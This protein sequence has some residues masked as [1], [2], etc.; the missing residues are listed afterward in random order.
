MKFSSR[1]VAVLL[2]MIGAAMA[3]AEDLEIFNAQTA[4]EAG[5]GWSEARIR[6]RGDKL[7]VTEINKTGV[8][9]SVYF[10]QRF[11]LLSAGRVVLDV[12]AV[13]SGVYTLQVLSFLGS[14]PLLS[15]EP[16]KNSNRP[17]RFDIS[18]SDLKL[19]TEAQSI[20][21]KLWLGQSEGANMILNNLRYYIPL[22]PE[23]VIFDDHFADSAKWSATDSILRPFSSGYE[24][25]LS[26]GKPY[27]NILLNHDFASDGHSWL[28]VHI[29]KVERGTITVQLVAF[30]SNG[31]YSQ[32]IDAIV[33]VGAG[34]H[35]VRTDSIEWPPKV[36]KFQVKIWLGGDSNCSAE[37]ARLLLIAADSL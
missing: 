17:G 29:P 20:L 16:V 23:D 36:G 15:D 19:P 26:E 31:D 2:A 18:V 6:K 24:M 28:L 27:G 32:S 35:G 21:F 25:T 13:P 3:L 10:D 37:F 11:P 33:A 1:A 5:W 4:P 30:D 22:P 7:I 34:W 14:S 9:G 8:V 12:E